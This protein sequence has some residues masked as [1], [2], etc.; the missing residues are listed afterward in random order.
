MDGYAVRS[1][2]IACVPATLRVVAQSAAGHPVDIRIEPGEA[3]R[4]FTGALVPAGADTIVLQEDTQTGPEQTVTVCA[5][6]PVD[7]HIRPAGLD[8]KV[9]EALL[10]AGRCLTFRDI[11]L[12]AAM[13]VSWLPVVRRPQVAILS[14]G[15]E[16]R[17]PGETIGPGDLIG[18]NGFALS[19]FVESH[20]GVAIDLGIARDERASLRT[21]VSAVRGA[22]LLLTSGGVSARLLEGRGATG[23]TADERI[24][25]WRAGDRS[26]RQSRLG[27][28]RCHSVRIAGVERPA[29]ATSRIG[30]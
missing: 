6:S 30:S 16:I 5:F 14:T 9:G 3:V 17:L 11:A 1:A 25:G 10:R 13:N 24:P 20:G 8:F 27:H 23:K 29:R 2:D 18:S 21:L 28:G 4:I 7:R 12:A 19:A 15:D 22:E 26:A